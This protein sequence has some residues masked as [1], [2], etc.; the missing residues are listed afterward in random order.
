MRPPSS[1]ANQERN[2]PSLEKD[3]NQQGCQEALLLGAAPHPMNENLAGLAY[4]WHATGGGVLLRSMVIGR[5]C[6][7][8]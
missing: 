6:V 3:F 5:I 4:F 1:T 2:R 7:L 8:L